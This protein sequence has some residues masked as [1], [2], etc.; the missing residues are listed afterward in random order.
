MAIH[1]GETK[2]KDYDYKDVEKVK[3]MSYKA[4]IVL[5]DHP[6]WIKNVTMPE[7]SMLNGSNLTGIYSSASH[8][9]PSLT[10]FK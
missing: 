4:W 2:K 9:V 3:W 8:D 1:V 7:G 5:G 6:K 10:S